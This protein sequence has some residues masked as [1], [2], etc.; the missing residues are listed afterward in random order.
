MQLQ[1]WRKLQLL[2]HSQSST[3]LLVFIR[4]T[5]YLHIR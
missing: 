2:S 3:F 5:F 4:L 1:S